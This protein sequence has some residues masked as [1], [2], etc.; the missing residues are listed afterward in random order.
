MSSSSSSGN[1][2]TNTN[3]DEPPHKRPKT[4]ARMSEEDDA[5]DEPNEYVRDGFV[6]DDDDNNYKEQDDDDDDL[7][8]SDVDEKQDEESSARRRFTKFELQLLPEDLDLGSEV[9]RS[10]AYRQYDGY[11]SDSLQDFIVE[12]DDPGL[13]DFPLQEDDDDS[14]LEEGEQQQREESIAA[15]EQAQK[16][17]IRRYFEPVQLVEQ[18]CTAR[19]EDIR[20]A[21][22]PERLYDLRHQLANANPVQDLE[23]APTEPELEHATWLVHH[24]PDLAQVHDVATVQEKEE[25][26]TSIAMAFRLMQQPRYLEPAFV[27]LYRQDY[28]THAV[29]RNH[30]NSLLDADKEWQRF[31]TAKTHVA[32]ELVM[33][34]QVPAQEDDTQGPWSA[35]AWLEHQIAKRATQIKV[36]QIEKQIMAEAEAETTEVS[37]L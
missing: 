14:L 18:L 23:A 28:V 36:R 17:H 3:K 19:D 10:P 4:E 9:A 25:I 12:A 26:L 21:D 37:I 30:L 35:G 34:A 20:Q 31:Q 22:L 24:V 2:N 1:P 11:D 5:D 8:D 13:V 7:V 6:V 33:H 27:Q 32:T 15:T 29:V 16:E